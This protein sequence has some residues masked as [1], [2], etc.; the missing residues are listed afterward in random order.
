MNIAVAIT[1]TLTS[2]FSWGV[3]LAE[4][5]ETEVGSAIKCEQQ[6]RAKILNKQIKFE[7][8]LAFASELESINNEIS[9]LTHNSFTV[10]LSRKGA[11][12]ATVTHFTASQEA[13]SQLEYHLTRAQED[14]YSL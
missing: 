6:I 5:G 14:P 4:E 9:N 11:T 13:L 3:A 8:N 1:L 2:Y 7:T 12:G 10:E